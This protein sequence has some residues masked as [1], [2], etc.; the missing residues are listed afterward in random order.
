MVFLNP[1]F[2][3]T[4]L[5]LSVPIAIHFWSKK[6]VKTIKIGST[7]FLTEMNPKQTSNVRL[8]EW[9][10]LLMRTLIIALI[11]LILAAPRMEIFNNERSITYL[12]EKSL[13]GS[14]KVNKILDT[15]SDSE[16]RLLEPGFPLLADIDF[17]SIE[18][19]V[20]NY[21]QLAQQMEA[22]E[23]DSIVVLTR[24]LQSGFKG[25]RP[26]LSVPIHWLQIDEAQSSS[27]VVEAVKS[28]DQV[29]LTAINSDHAV[30]DYIKETYALNNNMFTVDPEQDSILIKSNTEAIKLPL[31]KEKVTEVLIA[32]DAGFSAE[33]I[34]LSTAFKAL[35]KYLNH[36]IQ[37]TS[38]KELQGIDLASFDVLVWLK[39]DPLLTF[40]GKK[41]L[42]KP[43]ELAQ[44]L[45]EPGASNDIYLLRRHLDTENSIDLNLPEQLIG[46]LGLHMQLPDQIKTFDRRIMDIQELQVNKDLDG[47][48][49]RPNKLKDISL[50]L[51]LLLLLLL[52]AERIL[53]KLRKQ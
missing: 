36:G 5:G 14:E 42:W 33:T 26:A 47:V 9:V 43:D 52:P 50:W 29:V 53:S 39:Q 12:V 20:P 1:L 46:F 35:S 37:I 31:I 32:A 48:S 51:W 28:K 11:A 49:K 34:Y 24:G 27:S 22:L 16:V 25:M 17:L 6:K 21:W 38:V 3:W 19:S 23:T 15:I 8:N 45:I 44:S 40:S 2:L 18:Q 30:L 41:L 13:L 7:R 4:L 10:L